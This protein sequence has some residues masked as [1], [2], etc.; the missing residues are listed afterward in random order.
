M[1]YLAIGGKLCG[2][3]CIEDPVRKNAKDVITNLKDKGFR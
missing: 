2:V 1:V 3:L